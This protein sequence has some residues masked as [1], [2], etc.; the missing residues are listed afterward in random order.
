MSAIGVVR[1]VAEH[2]APGALEPRADRVDVGLRPDPALR[3]SQYRLIDWQVAFR[4][5]Q[6]AR[7]ARN[8]DLAH[9]L[10]WTGNGWILRYH[11][12]IV[13]RAYSVPQKIRMR[14]DHLRQ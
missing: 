7:P 4:Q 12:A 13:L 8:S 5:H 10:L 3:R 14:N 6:H 11:N 9:A 2:N 1:L